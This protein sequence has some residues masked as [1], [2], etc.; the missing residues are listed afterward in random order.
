MSEVEILYKVND[1][2]TWRD[3]DPMV[4]KPPGIYLTSGDYYQWSKGKEPEGITAL[5]PNIRAIHR[6]FIGRVRYALEGPTIEEAMMDE[7]GEQIERAANR[8]TEAASVSI[9]QLIQSEARNIIATLVGVGSLKELEA[10]YASTK[11]KL[12]ALSKVP[13]EQI[14]ERYL[15]GMKN[16]QAQA[17]SILRRQAQSSI[18]DIKLAH[19]KCLELG[20]DTNWGFDDVLTHAVMLSDVDPACCND[21][22]CTPTDENVKAWSKRKRRARR[23]YCIHYERILTKETIDKVRDPK[24]RVRPPRGKP[25]V[26]LATFTKEV[27]EPR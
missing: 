25:S 5:G 4:I 9:P 1:T 22:L 7:Y 26:T 23:G 18:D 14:R 24:E 16:K 20:Y 11:S 19:D 3:G 21:L 12:E 8:V 6:R 15:Q 27:M 17:L 2:N 10:R 13:P